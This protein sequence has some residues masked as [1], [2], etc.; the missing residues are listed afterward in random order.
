MKAVAIYCGSS[1]GN[2][3]IYTKTAQELGYLL[4]EKGVTMVYGAGNIGLMGIAANASLDKGGI[5]VG[6]IPHFLRKKEVCH[7]NLSELIL[8][9]SMN[10]RKVVMTDRSDATIVLPGGYGTLDELF[11]IVTLVQLGQ[12]Q[13]AIGILNVDGYY[14][15]LLQH[16]NRMAEDHFLKQ[17]HQQLIYVDSDAASLLEKLEQHQPKPLDGKWF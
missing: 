8:V 6:V 11:E 5:V 17:E 10:E 4:A 14:D 12:S 15:A 3:A 7:E 1:T 2:K 13:H 16:I 9:D